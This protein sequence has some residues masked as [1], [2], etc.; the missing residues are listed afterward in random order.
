MCGIDN[1]NSVGFSGMCTSTSTSTNNRYVNEC[2]L[3]KFF[4]ESPSSSEYMLLMLLWC[5]DFFLIYELLFGENC[6]ALLVIISWKNPQYCISF[7]QKY[8]FHLFCVFFLW[9][10][11]HKVGGGAL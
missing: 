3:D 5:N 2:Y 11:L 8:I 6:L 1:V 7:Y 9:K 4:L 10:I